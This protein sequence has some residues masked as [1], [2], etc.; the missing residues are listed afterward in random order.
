MSAKAKDELVD[1]RWLAQRIGVSQETMRRRIKAGTIP[2]P[3][4]WDR[5]WKGGSYPRPLWRRSQIEH[6]LTSGSWDEKVSPNGD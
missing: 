3:E 2:Q 5:L 4:Q 6:W 1:H